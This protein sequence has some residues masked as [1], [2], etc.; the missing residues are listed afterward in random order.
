MRAVSCWYTR[1]SCVVGVCFACC[2]VLDILPAS[3]FVQWNESPAGTPMPVEIITRPSNP[4]FSR[5]HDM[6]KSREQ[7][8][9][10]CGTV[11]IL[12]MVS[13]SYHVSHSACCVWVVLSGVGFGASSNKCCA[14]QTEQILIFLKCDWDPTRGCW[15]ILGLQQRFFLAIGVS[16]LRSLCFHRAGVCLGHQHGIRGGDE[17]RMMCRFMFRLSGSEEGK[18]S[19]QFCKLG[20]FKNSSYN[21]FVFSPGA[22]APILVDV[23]CCLL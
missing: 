8:L 18:R 20:E 19:V 2:W 6:S 21:K 5:F 13:I 16:E 22:L 10:A 9:N 17:H 4:K 14:N 3:L 1:Y 11:G 15:S 7:Q 23:V 12:C